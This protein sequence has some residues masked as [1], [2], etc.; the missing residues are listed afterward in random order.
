MPTP[1]AEVHFSSS[2][3]LSD[4]D[5]KKVKT[6]RAAASN[7]LALLDTEIALANLELE[8]D[9]D[10]SHD[11]S[12]TRRLW[13]NSSLPTLRKR[14]RELQSL[15]A[16][17]D[18][19][20]APHKYLPSEL[21]SY[22]FALTFL[23]FPTYLPPIRHRS[24]L[25]LCHVCSRWRT[26]SLSTPELWTN[27]VYQYARTFNPYTMMAIAE[28]W[29]G[30]SGS[31]QLLSLVITHWTGPLQSHRRDHRSVMG[32]LVGRLLRPFAKRYEHLDLCLP[33]DELHSLLDD[34]NFSLPA[35]ESLCLEYDIHG[36]VHADQ[37]T[38]GENS[39]VLRRA[40]KLKRVEL[41]HFDTFSI[42]ENIFNWSNLT[43]L[44][45]IN[46]RMQLVQSH[47]ILSKCAN[48]V[49][50]R[51]AI[52]GQARNDERRSKPI[53][54]PFLIHLNIG[55]HLLSSSSTPGHYTVDEIVATFF[56][57]FTLPKLKDLFVSFARRLH[58]FS[59]N[60]EPLI[61][62]ITRSSCEIEV[63]QM[64][65]TPL[66]NVT[67]RAL[68]DAIPGLKAL[69]IGVDT[70]LPRE[71]IQGMTGI[72]NSSVLLKHLECLVCLTDDLEAVIRMLEYRFN[73]SSSSTNHQEV[74]RAGDGFGE[75]EDEGSNFQI[76]RPTFIMLEYLGGVINHDQAL[77]VDRLR[78]GGIE[79]FMERSR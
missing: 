63:L 35:L 41:K 57:P 32:D 61:S 76:A 44:A 69:R 67:L 10:E 51:I 74:D 58:G 70:L 17:Y 66:R 38:L 52:H 79:I 11:T 72:Q 20:V 78:A 49:E 3:I 62:L 16:E 65:L 45:C 5:R 56:E 53:S 12:D 60:R 40:S 68:V 64:E 6:R 37:P 47:T 15:I 43:H 28:E 25:L 59:W 55:F 34:R 29:F 48:L 1:S 77:R 8:C 23:N 54:L 18:A 50:C 71:I 7:E 27:L 13:P 39:I 19:A 31:S 33:A 24:P 14:R 42:D 36:T 30:R 22:I 4:D 75:G 26:I 73:A 9:S 46:T 21:L 2:D